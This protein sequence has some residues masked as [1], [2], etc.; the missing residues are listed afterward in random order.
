M[1]YVVRADRVMDHVKTELG[2][3]PDHSLQPTHIAGIGP[4]HAPTQLLQI[5]DLLVS[6]DRLGDEVEARG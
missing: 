4:V 2:E 1:V 3:R 5:A 6:K